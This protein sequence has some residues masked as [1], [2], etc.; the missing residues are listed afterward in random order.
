M[1]D[2]TG[3]EICAKSAREVVGMLRAKEVSPKELL[4]A[5][6]ER[7]DQVG[8]AVNATVIQCR[9]RAYA[10]LDTVADADPSEPGWLGGLPIGIKDRKS[11]V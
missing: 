3:P 5:S 11:V 1:A 9:E 8:E 7:M 4:D 6:Y 10:Q 2:F